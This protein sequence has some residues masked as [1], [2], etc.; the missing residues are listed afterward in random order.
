MNDGNDLD[1]GVIGLGI[2][3]RAIASRLIVTDARTTGF[4]VDASARDWLDKHGGHSVAT[5]AEAVR[6]RDAIALIVH[7]E[8]QVDSVLFGDGGLVTAAAPGVLV[9]LASTVSPRFVRSVDERLRPYDIRLVD[10]PV[11]GGPDRAARGELSVFIGGTTE[12]VG[13]AEAVLSRCASR[14]FAAGKV[15]DGAAMKL[16]NQI[17]TAAHIVLTAEA[18]ALGTLAGIDAGLLIDAISQSAGVSRQFER[19]AA[20]MA[21]GD[22]RIDATVRTF[23]KDLSIALEMAHDLGVSAPMTAAARGVFAAAGDFG[24]L[25]SSDTM[26]IE[27]YRSGLDPSTASLRDG[28]PPS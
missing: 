22:H 15:G 14:V 17:L 28:A 26:L 1:V 8:S 19:R 7:N 6:G 9:W 24:L 27:A 25:D 12:D 16:V 13:R 21:T 5:V 4:D 20:R 3:G 2:M 10:G 11:S 23:L 18:L